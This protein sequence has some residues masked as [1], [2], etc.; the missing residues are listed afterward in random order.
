MKNGKIKL[1]WTLL[2][3]Q[4]SVKSLLKF[5]NIPVRYIMRKQQSSVKS[6]LKFANIPV[7]YYYENTLK[8]S[9]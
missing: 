2:E 6:L 4:S 1:E 3:Q 5:A 8:C 9:L 7:M